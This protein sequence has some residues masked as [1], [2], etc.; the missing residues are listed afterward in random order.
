MLVGFYGDSYC[1]N[2][3]ER[4]YPIKTYID[5]VSEYVG[6]CIHTGYGGSSHWDLI[7]KQFD[8]SADISVFLW[9]DPNRLY[10]EKVRHIR[11]DSAL[12][13]TVPLWNRKIWIAA[14]HYYKYLH[15]QEKAMYEYKS[16]LAYFDSTL[17]N[18]KYIHLWS[19]EPLKDFSFKNGM[20]INIGLHKEFTIEDIAPNHLPLQKDNDIIFAAIKHCIDNYC[21]GETYDF[22]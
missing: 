13:K 20:T 2:N 11:L 14:K 7:L 21:T 6:E 5:Q 19:F 12:S 16:S 8:D 9:T 15:N 22:R 3:K 18:K 10:H 17:G 4:K 1:E